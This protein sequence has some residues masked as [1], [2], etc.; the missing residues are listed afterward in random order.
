MVSCDKLVYTI[1]VNRWYNLVPRLFVAL[2]GKTGLARYSGGDGE[3]FVQDLWHLYNAL[4]GTEDDAV[5]DKNILEEK[6]VKMRKWT[7][8]MRQTVRKKPSNKIHPDNTTTQMASLRAT[9]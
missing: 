9:K 3:A 6:K 8:N 7:T 2:R 4:D 5:F 1:C